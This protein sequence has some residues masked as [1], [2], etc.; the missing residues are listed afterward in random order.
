MN[1]TGRNALFSAGVRMENGALGKKF[2]TYLKREFV[3]E[4]INIKGLADHHIWSTIKTLPAALPEPSSMDRGPRTGVT[5][6]VSLSALEVVIYLQSAFSSSNRL[7][8]V[9]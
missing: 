6:G 2:D 5:E 9:D 4:S 3:T 1:R 7:N 8:V